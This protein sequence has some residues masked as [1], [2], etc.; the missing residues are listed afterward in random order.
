MINSR[1]SQITIFIILGVIIVIGAA[2]YFFMRGGTTELPAQLEVT[3]KTPDDYKPI[4][5][6]VETCLSK[7]LQEAFVII[8]Q[9]GGYLDMRD[10]SL[11]DRS[12]TLAADD[13]TESDAAFLTMDPSTHVAY[14]WHMKS[15]NAVNNFQLTDD[16][17][18]SIDY[19][20]KQSNKYIEAKLSE[21][22]ADFKSFGDQGFKVAVISDPVA[23][24]RVNEKDVSVFLTFPINASLGSNSIKM[25]QFFTKIPLGFKEFYGL[26]D[27]IMHA[28]V[29]T[30]FLEY[31]VK[32]M[33]GVY[34]TS[35]TMSKLPPIYARE[36]S[37]VPKM[38]SQM[39]VKKEMQ[40]LL[41]SY[42]PLMTING[43]KN[44]HPLSSPDPF[45]NGFYR[46]F[47]Y[48]SLL[49]QSYPEFSVN[50]YYFG[51]PIYL[52]IT[53]NSGDMI[54]P[55]SDIDIPLAMGPFT[56]FHTTPV[57]E[58]EYF[59]D[60]S[61]PVII[62]IKRKSD[63]FGSGYTLFFSLES[64]MRDNR[65]MREWLDGNGTY[66]TDLQK[67]FA[68]VNAAAK[69]LPD[70]PV[71]AKQSMDQYIN[72]TSR[73]VPTL[74]C[75]PKQRLSGNITVNVKDGSTGQGI[76]SAKVKFGCGKYTFCSIGET[77]LDPI[78]NKSKSITKFPLCRGGGIIR[79]EKEGY[80]D[81]VI[82]DITTKWN[83]SKD[84]D[85]SLNPIIEKNVKVSKL[86]L[87]RSILYWNPND[88]YGQNYTKVL[89]LS[90][91]VSQPTQNN[92]SIIITIRK[93][94]VDPLVNFQTQVISYDNTLNSSVARLAPGKYEV[95]V[96]YFVLSSINISS[97]VRCKD[98][99]EYASYS[100][101]DKGA[102]CYLLPKD[103]MVLSN[104]IG[105]GLNLNNN[106]GY[107]IV[108]DADLKA[109]NYIEIKI[110][111]FPT[112]ILVEDIQESGLIENM[113]LDYRS[114]L[115]PVFH[116]N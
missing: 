59:Y 8:G 77:S 33:I 68:P 1:K 63:L 92:E 26:A 85:V 19:I 113:S 17:K 3:E 42:V 23:D 90:N 96:N 9:H 62:E 24:T 15:K 104:R 35:A 25:T 94:D 66:G 111:E 100:R 102:Q 58:Y 73:E 20:Q 4:K 76:P 67:I 41:T 97:S 72:Q 18:P 57:K 54:P 99:D 55:S 69:E 12:F 27:S 78:T 10:T 2:I 56:L 47:Y 32:Q 84:F 65:V 48:N 106:T 31:A 43:T 44:F 21:C 103:P 40:S 50:F 88:D 14:W 83:E 71:L 75:N 16:N 22:L 70:N 74:F 101:G 11:S 52:Y 37:N 7:K 114:Q 105:G 6:F 107:W 36:T 80:I 112:P 34:G 82:L 109:K 110:L 116:P 79:V 86:L 28:E 89:K 81:Q 60:V 13:P 38:W 53:P 64:N 5:D 39:V 91:I 93:V 61:Y 108:S 98:S 30:S 49:N 115:Q 95:S 45:V 46:S 29:N 51:W 87:N